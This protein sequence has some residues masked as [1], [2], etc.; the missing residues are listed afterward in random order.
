MGEKQ[1]YI[2]VNEGKFEIDLRVFGTDDYD[3]LYNN[4]KWKIPE[5]FN[6]GEAISRNKEGTAIIY[7]DDQGNKEEINYSELNS[8]SNQVANFLVELGVKRGEPVGVMMGPRAESAADYNWDLQGRS[9]SP[10]NDSTIWS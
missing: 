8:L 4:F 1:I 9:Y 6:M 5:Y 2:M 10:L 7:R 3:L